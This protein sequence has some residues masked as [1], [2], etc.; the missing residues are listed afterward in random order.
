MDGTRT[1]KLPEAIGGPVNPT[2][3]EWLMG[4]PEGWTD[5]EDSETP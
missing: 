4:F 2:W 5:V 3:A 1:P